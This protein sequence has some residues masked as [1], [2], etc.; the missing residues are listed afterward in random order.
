M[1]KDLTDLSM[2]DVKKILNQVDYENV[3]DFETLIAGFEKFTTADEDTIS[4]D[5]VDYFSSDLGFSS[6]SELIDITD[7]EI[8]DLLSFVEE[9]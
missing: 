3:L 6:D 7:D 9:L 2:G 8:Q 1:K 5:I 4:V